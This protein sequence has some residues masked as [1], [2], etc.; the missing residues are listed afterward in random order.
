MLWAAGEPCVC[1]CAAENWMMLDHRNSYAFIDGTFTNCLLLFLPQ[2]FVCVSFLLLLLPLLLFAFT[3][4]RLV[5]ALFCEFNSFRHLYAAQYKNIYAMKAIHG[6]QMNE[7][8]GRYRS[9]LY[10]VF[11]PNY[12][13]KR[14]VN[15]WINVSHFCFQFSFIHRTAPNTR[16]MQEYTLWVSHE[17]ASGCAHPHWSLENYSEKRIRKTVT[18]VIGSE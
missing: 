10:F 17:G 4:I 5:V 11:F 1:L 2:H 12:S 13:L 15:V 8:R 7:R 16:T 18:S 3:C 6:D 14:F 9:I